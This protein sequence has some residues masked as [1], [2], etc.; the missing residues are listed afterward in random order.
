[1]EKLENGI[2]DSQHLLPMK[3]LYWREFEE[4]TVMIRDCTTPPTAEAT[5]LKY[6]EIYKKIVQNKLI[7][8]YETGSVVQLGQENNAVQYEKVFVIVSFFKDSIPVETQ[9]FPKGKY[10]C[11]NYN[12]D[13]R[14]EQ[15]GKLKQ[16][17]E[18]NSLQPK[19]IIEADTFV[20]VLDYSNPM[21]ELQVL[22]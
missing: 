1:M 6:F 21:M 9:T 20:D 4:R 15:L 10:L 2:I 12:A 18:Q 11:V 19:L 22:L 3:D 14:A 8:I 17:L 13:N 5:Y 7:T 16:T